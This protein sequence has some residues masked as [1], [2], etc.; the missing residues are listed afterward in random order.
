MTLKRRVAALNLDTSHF[1][2]KG[3]CKGLT[4]ETSESLRAGA[5]K[6]SVKLRGRPRRVLTKEHRQSISRSASERSFANN[7]RVKWHE[8]LNPTSNLTIK[9]QG[10]WEKRYVEW[11]NSQ[12]IKWERPRETF[13]WCCDENDIKHV[14]HP[15]FYLPE[16]GVF[17]EIK[18]YMWKDASKKI[19]D[20]LKLRLVQEQNPQMRLQVLMKDDLQK[21]GVL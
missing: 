5:E 21:M 1:T 15:D 11:L 17:V 9:V 12:N 10:T 8:V 6:T 4:S 20:E 7:T 2:G 16:T 14:Y 18:G 3:W 19:D 13:T